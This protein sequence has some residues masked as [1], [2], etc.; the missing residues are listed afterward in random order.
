MILN[1]VTLEELRKLWDS[2]T[3]LRIYSVLY[4]GTTV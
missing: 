1:W 2:P 4:A 3:K